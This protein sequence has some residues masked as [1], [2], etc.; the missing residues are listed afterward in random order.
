MAKWI[1]CW[2]RF[3]QFHHIRIQAAGICKFRN[4]KWLTFIGKCFSCFRIHSPHIY[5]WPIGKKS[6]FY[7]ARFSKILLFHWLY[8]FRP[9]GYWL[10]STDLL[11]S[12]LENLYLELYQRY[13]S[14]IRWFWSHS[15][16]YRAG[17]SI[18]K[19]YSCWKCFNYW[20]VHIW[21]SK[22]QA[23]YCWNTT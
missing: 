9:F 20:S 12:I 21:S 8:N 22:E 10:S 17:H 18:W 6:G 1:W 13:T 19:N 7:Q 23:S 4:A 2:I 3:S 14:H 16:F 5:S 11:E 15:K